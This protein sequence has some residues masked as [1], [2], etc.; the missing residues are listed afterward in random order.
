MLIIRCVEHLP[1]EAIWRSFYY[2]NDI[3]SQQVHYYEPEWRTCYYRKDTLL[4]Q[5]HYYE[6]EWSSEPTMLLPPEKPSL[7]IQQRC[8]IK[9]NKQ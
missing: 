4:E 5:V 1:Y 3:L 2:R 7:R 9:S 8:A 6:P